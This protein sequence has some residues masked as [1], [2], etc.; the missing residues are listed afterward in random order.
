M[1][2]ESATGR[3]H[4]ESSPSTY[5]SYEDIIS[6]TVHSAA[7]TST[8]LKKIQGIPLSK[9][10]TKTGGWPFLIEASTLDCAYKWTLESRYVELMHRLQ[11]AL[12]TQ[13]QRLG[14]VL[15]R[16]SAMLAKVGT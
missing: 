2:I 5:T 9:W 14:S 15:P 4:N 3:S 8:P 7:E 13:E 11:N 16:K 1:L 10:K 6:R 12:D